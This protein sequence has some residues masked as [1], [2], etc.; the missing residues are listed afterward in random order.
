MNYGFGAAYRFDFNYTHDSSF[1]TGQIH[2]ITN[3]IPTDANK[4]YEYDK[5]G[6]LTSFWQSTLRSDTPWRKMDFTYDRYG[7]IINVVDKQTSGTTSYNFTVDTATNRL[8]SRQ[9]YGGGSTTF[10]YDAAGNITTYGTFDAENRITLRSGTTCMYDGNGRKFRTQGGGST[11]NYVYSSSGVLLVEDNLTASTTND[12]IYFQGKMVAVHQQDGYLIL[13]IKDYL[14]AVFQAYKAR[15]DGSS[16]MNNWTYEP[17]DS[18]EPF[19]G[20]SLTGSVKYGYQDKENQNN[21]YFFGA[22]DYSS[23]TVQGGSSLRWCSPD[24]VTSNIYDPQSLNK[25][26]YVRN[27]PVN[28]IDPDGRT[29]MPFYWGYLWNLYQAFGWVYGEFNPQ[30]AVWWIFGSDNPY[31]DHFYTPPALGQPISPGTATSSAAGGS[32]GASLKAILADKEQ[33]EFALKYR[34]I[35][36]KDQTGKCSDFL[37]KVIENLKGTG[38]VANDFSIGKLIGNIMHATLNPTTLGALGANARTNP[39]RNVINIA[40]DPVESNGNDYFSTL[41]H[42]GFHLGLTAAARHGPI[43]DDWLYKAA[44]KAVGDI[45]VEMSDTGYSTANKRYFGQNCG[46]GI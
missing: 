25:Y 22:R 39:R 31:F 29:D 1:S 19:G 14:G 16:W 18:Y 43:Y 36:G 33:L 41:L 34:A 2:D 24:P 21:L 46:P 13:L 8:L 9:N 17:T 44:A 30:T 37:N 26:S 27:D 7:N 15:P 23:R 28:K 3:G 10:S 45:P 35:V 5:W 32:G 20:A 12:F 4:H 40:E 11:I 38:S 42:E 6:R